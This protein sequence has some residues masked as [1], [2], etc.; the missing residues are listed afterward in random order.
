[1]KKLQVETKVKIKESLVV[2]DFYNGL[3]FHNGMGKYK[4][5]IAVVIG[6]PH[7]NENAYQIDIDTEGYDWSSGMFEI[8]S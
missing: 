8:V 1:M 3:R 2:D 7:Y 5:K 4:G 6:N